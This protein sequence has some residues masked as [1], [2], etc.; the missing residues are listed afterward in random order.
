MLFCP[1]ARSPPWQDHDQAREVIRTR[2]LD[3][4]HV[5]QSTLDNQIEEMERAFESSHLAYLANTDQRTQE[6]KDLTQKDQV[7]KHG[8]PLPFFAA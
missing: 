6:F 4:I 5:L 7:G 3:A 1:D 2:S 8:L